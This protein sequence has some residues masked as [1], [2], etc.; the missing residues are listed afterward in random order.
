MAPSRPG[1][2][3]R[4]ARGDG[5]SRE[6]MMNHAFTFSLT[7]VALLG[8]ATTALAADAPGHFHP[9]GKQPSTFTLELRNGLKAELPFADKRDFDEAARGFI[10]APPY[11]QI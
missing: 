4:D 7:L 6:T 8:S 3:R 2:A 1:N 10:A 5:A 11:K 9:K